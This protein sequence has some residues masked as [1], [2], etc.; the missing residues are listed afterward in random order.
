[1]ETGGGGPQ[2]GRGGIGLSEVGV[3]DGGF[4]LVVYI[5][6]VGGLVFCWPVEDEVDAFLLEVC[7]EVPEGVGVLVKGPVEGGTEGVGVGGA[8]GPVVY[9]KL[10]EPGQGGVAGELGGFE[11]DAEFVAFVVEGAVV[12]AAVLAGPAIGASGVGGYID[13]AEEGVKFLEVGEMVV[14]EDDL[15]VVVDGFL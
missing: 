15:E 1:M 12:E 6:E 14:A 7:D 8:A 4:S 11:R 2:D 13:R 10:F 5:D 9:E 3:G